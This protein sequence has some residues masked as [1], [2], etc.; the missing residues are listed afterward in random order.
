M[1]E[2]IRVSAGPPPWSTS[3]PV[4][5]S[6]SPSNDAC[7]RPELA[8]TSHH[9]FGLARSMRRLNRPRPGVGRDCP[10]PPPRDCPAWQSQFH[11]SPP[12]PPCFAGSVARQ[13]V[14]GPKD[15]HSGA[16]GSHFE[17]WT[18]RRERALITSARAK[19]SPGQRVLLVLLLVLSRAAAVPPRGHGDRQTEG[20]TRRPRNTLSPSL[21]HH[22]DQCNMLEHVHLPVTA[23]FRLTSHVRQAASSNL[24]FEDAP[25]ACRH[26]SDRRADRRPPT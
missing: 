24:L 1:C 18:N 15:C 22:A 19:R 5:P 12:P 16:F 14:Q 8:K 4:A 13:R 9:P 25:G 2:L 3:P 10:P 6:L 11:P 20:K 17:R 26:R 21:I 23:R 7:L